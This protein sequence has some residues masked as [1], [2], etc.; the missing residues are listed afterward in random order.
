VLA[1]DADLDVSRRHL[2]AGV[3]RLRTPGGGGYGEPASRDETLI[4]RDL[5]LGKVS[6]ERV[7]T[8]YGL[9]PDAL[10][11]DGSDTQS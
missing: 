1:V 10:G 5:R 11:A 6:R 7:R 3:A 2:G 9:D 8:V 4:A